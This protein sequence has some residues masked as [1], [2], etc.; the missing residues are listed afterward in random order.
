MAYARLSKSLH[1]WYM[2]LEKTWKKLHRGISR[3]DLRFAS[4]LRLKSVVNLAGRHEHEG[5]LNWKM[6]VLFFLALPY[7]VQALATNAPA[8]MGVQLESR[9]LR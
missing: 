8:E 4:D 7:L 6:R 9:G 1:S 2:S 5:I 3:W